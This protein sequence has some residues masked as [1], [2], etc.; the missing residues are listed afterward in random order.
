MTEALKKRAKQLYQSLRRR[1]RERQRRGVPQALW[2]NLPKLEMAFTSDELAYWLLRVS[3]RLRGGGQVWQ[4]PYTKSFLAIAEI[5]I[6]H[7]TPLDRG[8]MTALDNFA[9]TD[10]RTNRIKSNLSPEE[11]KRLRWLVEEFDARAAAG[12]WKRLAQPPVHK[13]NELR[14]AARKRRAG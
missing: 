1:E 3:C 5:T 12:I 4:C 7:V 6:D 14:T 8:G 11:F 9:V 2:S 13:M 10:P